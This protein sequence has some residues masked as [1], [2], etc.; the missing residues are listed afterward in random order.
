MTETETE[1][2]TEMAVTMRTMETVKGA[3]ETVA[4]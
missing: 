3:A 1:T 2:E 4:N